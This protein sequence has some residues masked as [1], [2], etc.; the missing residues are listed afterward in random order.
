MHLTIRRLF[1]SLLLL[2]LPLQAMAVASMTCHMR[3]AQSHNAHHQDHHQPSDSYLSHHHHQNHHPGHSAGQSHD[4]S[5]E[6]DNLAC[7]LCSASCSQVLLPPAR[8]AAPG[9]S[10]TSSTL[11]LGVMQRF[12]SVVSEGLFRPPRS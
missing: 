1:A 12:S 2:A 3:L 11:I 9:S 6:V 10:A 5:P 8:V 4:A 7:T